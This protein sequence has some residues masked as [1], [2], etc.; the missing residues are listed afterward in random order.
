MSFT[1]RS[2]PCKSGEKIR[3]WV[4]DQPLDFD[5]IPIL[6]EQ[7][8]NKYDL[9]I[10][11]DSSGSMNNDSFSPPLSNQ[12]TAVIPSSQPYTI[13]YPTDERWV[14]WFYQSISRSFKRVILIFINE[15]T[16]YEDRHGKVYYKWV[17]TGV[18]DSYGREE[19][20]WVRVEEPTI[21][22]NLI[23][24]LSIFAQEYKNSRSSF[25]NLYVVGAGNQLRNN[26]VYAWKNE[27]SGTGYKYEFVSVGSN[28]G[29]KVQNLL[30]PNPPYFVKIFVLEKNRWAELR[31][32]L[33]DFSPAPYND[34]IQD[35]LFSTQVFEKNSDSEIDVKW[36]CGGRCPPGYCEIQTF[37]YPYYCCIR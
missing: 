14:Y 25:G 19:G 1:F 6:I 30:T 8:T 18:F 28:V 16:P 26:A 23:K 5:G 35:S 32:A 15:S 12:L 21:S 3:V 4:D 33:R 36:T 2:K 11:I 13:F 34:L 7:T 37:E 27:L 22:F 17:G 29:E 10:Y 20:E 9:H 31:E 24:D